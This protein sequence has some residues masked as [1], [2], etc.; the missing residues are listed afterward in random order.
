MSVQVFGRSWYGNTHQIPVWKVLLS[1]VFVVVVVV[2]VACV[3]SD[4]CLVTEKKEI[5]K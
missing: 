1:F 5:D 4:P 3:N 2:T